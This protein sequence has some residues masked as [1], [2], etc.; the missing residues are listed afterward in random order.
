M[1]KKRISTSSLLDKLHRGAVYTCLGITLYG[2][3][4]L[5]MRGWR[6]YTVVRPERQQADLKMLEEG[7]PTQ[8]NDT[9]KELKC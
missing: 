5:G 7:A 2:T 8:N 6:Y 3:F 1:Q 9:A 4:L